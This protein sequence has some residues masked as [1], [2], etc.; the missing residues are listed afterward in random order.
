LDDARWLEQLPADRPTLLIAE[1]VLP[2]LTPRQLSCL[3]T[4]LSSHFAKAQMFFDAYD[5]L[6]TWLLSFDASIRATG[7]SLQSSLRDLR[8]QSCLR[9]MQRHDL[10]HVDQLRHFACMTRSLIRCWQTLPMLGGIAGLYQC[11]L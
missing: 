10:Y 3:F 4:A 7:A 5:R 2:Y 1:G 11:R 8:L 6:G 9:L